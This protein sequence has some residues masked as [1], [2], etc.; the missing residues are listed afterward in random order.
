MHFLG[1]I[2]KNDL[3]KIGK[4]EFIKKYGSERYLK[5]MVELYQISEDLL[6]SL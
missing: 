4:E 1:G 6:L 5:D 2:A 3:I